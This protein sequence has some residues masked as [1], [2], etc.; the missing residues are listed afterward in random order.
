[1]IIM[2]YFNIAEADPGGV[3]GVRTPP[4]HP[5]QKKFWRKKE[6]KKKKEKE[7]KRRDRKNE[8]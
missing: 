4:F 3:P 7:K 8:K 2:M 1:M 6:K 5:S